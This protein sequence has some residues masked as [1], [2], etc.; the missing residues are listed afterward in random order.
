MEPVTGYSLNLL[1]SDFSVVD[2][3]YQT[4]EI[5]FRVVFL[6]SLPTTYTSEETDT[7]LP[8]HDCLERVIA[9]VWKE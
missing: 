1:F 4:R 8:N 5:V 3:I 9:E 6:N 2:V 7:I